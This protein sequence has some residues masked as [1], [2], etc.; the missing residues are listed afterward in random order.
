MPASLMPIVCL[1]M[2]GLHANAASRQCAPVRSAVRLRR[3]PTASML[4]VAGQSARFECHSNQSVRF[5]LSWQNPLGIRQR[6]AAGKS[7]KGL[8][9]LGN[10]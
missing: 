10:G 3:L 4:P 8:D 6:G 5:V 1:P 2:P 9:G 7:G